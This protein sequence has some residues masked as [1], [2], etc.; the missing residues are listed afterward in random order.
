[1]KTIFRFYHKSVPKSAHLYHDPT[2]KVFQLVC[3]LLGKDRRPPAHILA[4]EALEH[5]NSNYM[6]KVFPSMVD[7]YNIHKNIMLMHFSIIIQR[8][9]YEETRESLNEANLF[10]Q[11]CEKYIFERYLDLVE[12]L[13]DIPIKE[14]EAELVEMLV[15]DFEILDRSIACYGYKKPFIILEEI[16]SYN[17]QQ[18]ITQ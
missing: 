14:F 17:M 6:K 15:K 3:Q 7:D 11:L 10:F 9:E 12:D 8:L 4:F 13:I 16:P 1:M 2:P 18:V 5:I